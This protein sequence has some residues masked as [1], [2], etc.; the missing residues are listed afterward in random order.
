MVA[1]TI[2]RMSGLNLCTVRGTGDVLSIFVSGIDPKQ[3]WAPAK[4]SW[5]LAIALPTKVSQIWKLHMGQTL[6]TLGH[7]VKGH[8]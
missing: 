8:S 4:K 2:S 3:D 1:A 7:S 6:F 5:T